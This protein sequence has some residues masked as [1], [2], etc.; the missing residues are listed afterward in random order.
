MEVE[1]LRQYIGGEWV[2]STSG[3]TF[4]TYDPSSEEVLATVQRGNARDVDWA[5][6]AAQESFERSWV[7][8]RPNERA[9]LLYDLSRLI[10]SHADDLA[11]IES[12]DSGIPFENS[13]N[14]MQMTARYFEFYAG[15]CDK[16]YGDSI[17]LGSDYIDFTLREP[18]GVTAH[19]IPWNFPLNILARSVA[20][21]L[22]MGNTVVVKPAEQT[23]IT[24]LKLV[25]LVEEAG[26]PEGVYNVVTGYGEEAGAPL[27]KHAGI[28]SLT[29]TGSVE[30]GKKIM[31]A[32]AYNIKP[33]VMEL[34]GKSPAIL[35]GDANLEIALDEV[36]RGIYY[37]SGQVCSAPSRLLVPSE[38]QEE[39]LGKLVEKSK[40][41]SVGPALES[42][43]M[44]PLVSI[45]QYER[46]QGYI[47]IGREEG[48]N[49][50][51]GGGRPE[52]LSRGFFVSPTI[53]NDVS[54]EMRVANEEIFGPVLCVLPFNDEDEAL[55]MAN[56][57][58]YGLV[59]GI[60]TNDINRAL[61]LAKQI[62]AGQIYINEYY[63]G[64][65][66]T[67]FGGYKQSGFG[68]EKGMEALLNYTQVKN[69]AIR[70]R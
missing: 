50:A 51:A 28:S 66:E 11:R 58:D 15:S 16:F 68:R 13:R 57:V 67:P 48:A 62:K 7:D 25:E 42:P 31:E 10:E 40:T 34:G 61:R 49:V 12:Q 30:T 3:E 1:N 32:V 33:L 63:A 44:G 38:L 18:L 47:D 59:A 26:F 70:L 45:E 6:Q 4:E 35:F 53:L 9:R 14:E 29:F 17:P 69:I 24:A 21:A 43:D 54:L 27:S 65:V 55:E 20:P 19:I 46:V 52:G 23:P 2:E 64:G 8:S 37:H 5:V 39:V 22:A 56:A 36:T 41:I 60:F